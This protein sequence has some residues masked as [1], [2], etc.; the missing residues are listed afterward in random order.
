MLQYEVEGYSK[1]QFALAAVSTASGGWIA[2]LETPSQAEEIYSRIFS[3]INRRYL[4][5]YYAT[6]KEHDGKKR[7]VTISV[8]D[9]PGYMVM[10]R[11]GYYS[12]DP[13]K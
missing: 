4:V 6:N 3:D 10:G 13:N 7:K 2:F 12:P 8:R 11:Q 5:G 1:T 9:H